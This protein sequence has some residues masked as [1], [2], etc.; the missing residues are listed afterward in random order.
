MALTIESVREMEAICLLSLV[1]PTLA[2]ADLQAPFPQFIKLSVL[3]ALSVHNLGL[4][5]DLLDLH[6]PTEIGADFRSWECGR[7]GA[8]AG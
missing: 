4:T 5:R 6:R 2:L 1:L 3:A 7:Y 8:R